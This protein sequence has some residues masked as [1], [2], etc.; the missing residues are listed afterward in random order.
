MVILNIEFG[1][2][3]NEW[4]IHPETINARNELLLKIHK[5]K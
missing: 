4:L 2:V 3:K 5:I 1:N